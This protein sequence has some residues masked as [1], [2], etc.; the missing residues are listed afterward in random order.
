MMILSGKVL[1]SSMYFLRALV[2]AGFMLPSISELGVSWMLAEEMNLVK[3]A[4]SEA[5]RAPTDL[6]L[7]IVS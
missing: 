6:D 4:L 5:T 7:A 3:V 1:L 2:M